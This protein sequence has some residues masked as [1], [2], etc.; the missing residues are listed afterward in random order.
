MSSNYTAWYT[1]KIIDF[2][3]P[4]YGITEHKDASKYLEYKIMGNQIDILSQ[5]DV[6]IHGTLDDKNMITVGYFQVYGEFSG[7]VVDIL[8]PA[9]EQSTGYYFAATIWEG[10]TVMELTIDDGDVAWN[11][12]YAC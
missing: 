4:F 3:I 5:G 11:N 10:V 7:T 8:E 6:I 1:G 2:K 9:L 12:P